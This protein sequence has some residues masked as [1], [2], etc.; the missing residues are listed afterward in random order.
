MRHIPETRSPGPHTRAHNVYIA[1]EKLSRKTRLVLVYIM[2][3]WPSEIYGTVYDTVCVRLA[4]RDARRRPHAADRN[5]SEYRDNMIHR[6]A[7]R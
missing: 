6:E 1:A 4:E 5:E 2:G 3:I 7:S